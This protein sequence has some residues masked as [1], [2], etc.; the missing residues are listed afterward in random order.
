MYYSKTTRPPFIVKHYLLLLK[1]MQV[2]LYHQLTL[3]G[4]LV[5]SQVNVAESKIEEL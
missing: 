3:G 4:N 5:L 1:N 2:S